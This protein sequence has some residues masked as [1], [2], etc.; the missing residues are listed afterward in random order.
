MKY[1]LYFHSSGITV[2]FALNCSAPCRNLTQLGH[3]YLILACFQCSFMDFFLLK[4]A[5]TQ[6]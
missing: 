5:L 4:Y 2:M 6:V 3:K 1:V